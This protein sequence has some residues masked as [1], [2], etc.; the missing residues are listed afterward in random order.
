MHAKK[1]SSAI[2]EIRYYTN[3]SDPSAPV[4]GLGAIA[5]AVTDKMTVLAMLGRAALTSAE[6]ATVSGYN[7]TE[8]ENVWGM[9]SKAFNLAWEQRPSFDDGLNISAGTMLK[10]LADKY[11]MSLH[12]E[13][14][15]RLN[16][17]KR[18]A[19]Q[20]QRTPKS[21]GGSV[22]RLLEAR[23]V[24][25]KRQTRT[26]AHARRSPPRSAAVASPRP[27]FKETANTEAVA[28]F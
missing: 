1:L 17:P 20:V 4:I 28:V 23:L 25:E 7:R 15:Q 26:T 9:L 6:L 2:S 5:E 14:P 8:L 13:T 10:F 12:F 3:Y 24:P 18:V 27:R 11:S 19:E 21:L 16:I 22:L